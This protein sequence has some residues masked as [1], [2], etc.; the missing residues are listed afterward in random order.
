[1][2]QGTF[3]VLKKVV[4]EIFKLPGLVAGRV[5]SNPYDQIYMKTKKKTSGIGCRQGGW[6]PSRPNMQ[7]A[8]G[9]Y[10]N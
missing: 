6:L 8:S 9:N 2:C 4:V 10:K 7:E 5:V 1:M 3:F